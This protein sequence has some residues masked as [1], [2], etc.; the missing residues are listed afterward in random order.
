V[1]SRSGRSGRT[2]SAP[3]RRHAYLDL[4]SGGVAFRALGADAIRAQ[5]GAFVDIQGPPFAQTVPADIPG[6]A[7]DAETSAQVRAHPSISTVN[8][9]TLVP[10][11]SVQVDFAVPDPVVP[12][13][14]ATILVALGTVSG[15]RVYQI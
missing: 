4:G 12:W 2:R 8:F 6:N 5:T 15:A 11:A 13:A 3:R 9:A 1:A 14:A 10:L 7:V